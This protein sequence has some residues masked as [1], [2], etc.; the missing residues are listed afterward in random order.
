[1][2]GITLADFI[3][4]LIDFGCPNDMLCEWIRAYKKGKELKEVSKIPED[5]S[6]YVIFNEKIYTAC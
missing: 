4:Y 2:N 3:D 5:G 6:I 1:M